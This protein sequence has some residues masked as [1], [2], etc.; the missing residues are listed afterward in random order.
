MRCGLSS[1]FFAY[2]LKSITLTHPGT[3]GVG[4][5][6]ILG[7]LGQLCDMGNESVPKILINDKINLFRKTAISIL[8]I[9][10]HNSFRV[11]FDKIGS[12]YFM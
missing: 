7:R 10:N 5:A 12:V 1:K 2:L 11:L 8:I 4:G 3:E 9:S 6:D